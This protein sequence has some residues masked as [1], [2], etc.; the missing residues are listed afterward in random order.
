MLAD[1][2]VSTCMLVA[3]HAA[4]WSL[5]TGGTAATTLA[6]YCYPGRW[7]PHAAQWCAT[8]VTGIHIH[9]V[10]LCTLGSPPQRQPRARARSG[11]AGARPAAGHSGRTAHRGPPRA[12]ATECRLQL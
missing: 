12:S 11:A 9:G 6:A 7:C 4:V 10:Q 2:H 8:H 3:N 1:E 5:L